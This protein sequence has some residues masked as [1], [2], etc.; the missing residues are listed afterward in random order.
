M[1][2]AKLVRWM[3]T[4]TVTEG[5]LV[6]QNLKILPFQCLYLKQGFI[7]ESPRGSWPPA[8]GWIGESA[9]PGEGDLP[10]G[11]ASAG[12]ERASANVTRTTVC[13]GST[14]RPPGRFS[15]LNSPCPIGILSLPSL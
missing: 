14:I 5:G 3:E 1:T 7:A 12:P 2:V 11:A 8:E 10:R 9:I 4:L 6:G 13:L 15:H